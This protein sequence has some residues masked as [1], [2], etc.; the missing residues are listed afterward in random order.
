MSLRCIWL[1]GQDREIEIAVDSIDY[2]LE[3]RG[4]A[5]FLSHGDEPLGEAE[6][7]LSGKAK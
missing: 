7:R 4:V 6:G 2:F 3:T 5:A 1:F